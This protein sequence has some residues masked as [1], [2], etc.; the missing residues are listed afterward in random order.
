MNRVQPAVVA[1]DIVIVLFRLAVIAK[2]AHALGHRFVIGSDGAAFATSPEILAWI[3]AK[4]GREADRSS[5]SPAFPSV[6]KY[7][8]P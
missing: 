2:H 8:A 3:E 1:F 6:E 7:S 4:G 5:F